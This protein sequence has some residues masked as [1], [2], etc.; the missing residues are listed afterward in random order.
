MNS[1][2]KLN[3]I[4]VNANFV[5]DFFRIHHG[6]SSEPKRGDFLKFIRLYLENLGYI[7]EDFENY[8]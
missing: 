1:Y 8:P 3:K 5:K 2:R 4:I 6:P 7:S